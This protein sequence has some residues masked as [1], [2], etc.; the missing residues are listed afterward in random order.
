[1]L[2]VPYRGSGPYCYAN[3]LAMMMGTD[4]PEPAVIETVT[5]SPFG[6]ELLG[7]ALPFFDPY[8]WTPETGVQDALTVLGWT[9]RTLS[10]G[11]PEDALGRLAS[12]LEAGPVMVGPIEMGHLRYQPGMTGPIAADH[13][14]IALGIECD[15][16]TVHDPQGY[17]YARLPL[18]DFMDAW[19]ADTLTYGRPYTT[20]THFTQVA[21][22][23]VDAA[24]TAALPRAVAWL[25]ADPGHPMP[26]GSLANGA[27]AL[28]LADLLAAGD[29]DVREH[30]VH[31]AIR[32]GARRLTDAATCLHRAGFIDAAATMDGQAR[33]VGS[34]QQSVVTGDTS[35]AVRTLRTLAPTYDN[36][37]ADLRHSL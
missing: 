22:V 6:M 31:F 36:L 3:S 7:G 14:L 15:H 5:G 35:T 16:L 2:H 37:R 10:G 11:E 21:R 26:A 32:V 18:P 8:G 12:L 17:P 28:A 4:A 13:Y 20:R 29:N 27:A 25:D 33:L 30:L 23:G 9:A 24:V 19:R 1:M 34:L